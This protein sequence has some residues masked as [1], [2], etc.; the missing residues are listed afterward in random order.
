MKR[1]LIAMAACLSIMAGCSNG[2][3]SGETE[4]KTIG[5]PCIY[6]ELQVKGNARVVAN[7]FSNVVTV[8]A[9]K[10][11]V[12]LVKVKGTEK[13]LKID[14]SSK[15]LIDAGRDAIVVSIPVSRYVGSLDFN[16][17]SIF[18]FSEMVMVPNVKFESKGS[19][20]YKGVLT[21]EKIIIKS[22]GSDVFDIDLNCDYARLV[23]NGSTVFGSM[24]TPIAAGE[25][26]LDLRGAVTAYVSAPGK[27]TGTV[28]GSS[29]LY[30]FGDFNYS[31]V[32]TLAS[33]KVIHEE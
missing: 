32:K 20:V 28:D 3:L 8:T 7:M 33:G 5:V 15:K 1:I 4:T 18:E 17:S 23:G 21:L 14:A 29:E 11:I 10:N 31:K 25:I 13:K 26:D 30:T 19:N 6:K 9:D 12:D 24:D 16:G 2:K 27:C 22:E